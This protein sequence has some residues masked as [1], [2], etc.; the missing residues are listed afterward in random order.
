MRYKTAFMN[1]LN[2]MDFQDREKPLSKED[3]Q[4][5]NSKAVCTILYMYSMETPF[6]NEISVWTPPPDA[7]IGTG[8]Y[9]MF[10]RSK[11]VIMKES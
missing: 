9:G 5:P 10:A 4:D 6:C 8:L 3:F 11:S 2:L 7:S 1:I